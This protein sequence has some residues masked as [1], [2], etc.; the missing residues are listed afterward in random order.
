ML[1]RQCDAE[2]YYN[3][4]PKRFLEYYFV[5]EIGSEKFESEV[6]NVHYC[7]QECDNDCDTYVDGNL[8]GTQACK[9]AL[10]ADP[11]YG[12]HEGKLIIDANPKSGYCEKCSPN[13]LS[14]GQETCAAYFDCTP[15]WWIKEGTSYSGP[16]TASEAS[17]GLEWG[18]CGEDKKS[19]RFDS[20]SDLMRNRLVCPQGLSKNDCCKDQASCYCK[21]PDAATM[22]EFGCDSPDFRPTEIKA[23]L[24]EEKFPFFTNMNILVVMLILI[25]FYLFYTQKIEPKKSK[26]KR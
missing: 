4:P 3:S 22:E 1:L 21:V 10:V 16:G 25:V 20:I 13:G 6:L 17:A 8:E 26:T 18:E 14:P 5:A 9:T 11:D 7:I 2:R 12:I 24:A 15:D 23:C 19:G